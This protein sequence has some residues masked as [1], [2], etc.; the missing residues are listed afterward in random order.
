MP[1]LGTAIVAGSAALLGS[2]IGVIGATAVENR[3]IK[4]IEARERLDRKIDA[5]SRLPHAE[6]IWLD[7]THDAT[8]RIENK[9]WDALNRVNKQVLEGSRERSFSPFLSTARL[10]GSHRPVA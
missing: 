7:L 9:D 6:L 10:R 4:A 8:N 1:H 3:R 2:V 5:M